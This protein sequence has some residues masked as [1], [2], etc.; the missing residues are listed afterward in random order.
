MSL[1]MVT[2]DNEPLPQVSNAIAELA[3]ELAEAICRSEP[4]EVLTSLL[5]MQHRCLTGWHNSAELMDDDLLD[6]PADELTA[7]Q[8]ARLRS[9]GSTAA[10]YQLAATA[11]AAM[12]AEMADRLEVTIEHLEG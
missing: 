3:A 8:V 1:A 12:A 2:G 5:V 11:A 10:A 9:Q 4:D 6:T 7:E